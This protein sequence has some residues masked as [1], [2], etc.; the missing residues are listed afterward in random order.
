[1]KLKL[2][3]QEKSQ[4]AMVHY[5]ELVRRLFDFNDLFFC[6]ENVSNYEKGLPNIYF[7]RK[8]YGSCV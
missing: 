4:K 8:Q 5:N 2:K 3:Q 6:C 7:I 1:M